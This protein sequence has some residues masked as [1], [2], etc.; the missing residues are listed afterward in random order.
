MLSVEFE[1]KDLGA[2]K[3]IIKM[4]ILRDIS[5]KKLFLLQKGYIQMVLARF[6]MSFAN[7]IDTPWAN[8]LHLAMFVH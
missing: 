7:P 3:K 5:Q 4:E 6:G 1:M 2:T 8:N